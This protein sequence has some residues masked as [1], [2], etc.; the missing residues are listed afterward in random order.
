MSTA[1]RILNSGL[2]IEVW[3]G[4]ITKEEVFDHVG[5]HWSDPNK[6]L[7]SKI[8]VDITRADF[9]LSIGE[10]DIQQIIDL[11]RHFRGK[12]DGARIAIVAG[13]DF[14]RASLFGRLAEREKLNVIVFNSITTACIWLGVKILEVQDCLKRIDAELLGSPPSSLSL[15]PYWD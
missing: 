15:T 10:K 13:N 9:D 7:D 1:S 4:K 5:R 3:A 11:Y 2:V 6:S 8:F 14:D 12:T